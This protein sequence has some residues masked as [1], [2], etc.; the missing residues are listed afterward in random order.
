MDRI[1]RPRMI[2]FIAAL[3]LPLAAMALG[4][5]LLAADTIINCAFI[6]IYI[7]LPV[8]TIMLLG[9][10]I[11]SNKKI[12]WKVILSVFLLLLFLVLF[13]G[14][15]AFGKHEALT[16]YENEEFARHYTQVENDFDL[17]PSLSEIGQPTRIEYYDYF[18]SV[19]VFYL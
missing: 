5:I 16:R 15:S 19:M 12:V 8:C 7:A 3:L 14:M 17:M 4:A 13:M 9:L 6:M 11:F 10:C 2:A 18:S 1:T